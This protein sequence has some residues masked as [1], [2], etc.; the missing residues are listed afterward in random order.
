MAYAVMAWHGLVLISYIL[1]ALKEGLANV[2]ALSW[3]LSSLDKP[4]QG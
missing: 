3:R 4:W 2:T 1:K